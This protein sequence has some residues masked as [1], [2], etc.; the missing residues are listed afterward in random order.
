M[1]PPSYQ[2]RPLYTP[3]QKLL[4]LKRTDNIQKEDDVI[5]NVFRL[6]KRSSAA[7]DNFG[8][9]FRLKKRFFNLDN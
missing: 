6:R 2:N 4:K 9:V 7:N 1:N 3:S 8:N 5:D